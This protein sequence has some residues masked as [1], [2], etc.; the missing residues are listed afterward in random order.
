MAEAF[1][2]GENDEKKIRKW[3][4]E[5]TL[6]QFKCVGHGAKGTHRSVFLCLVSCCVSVEATDTTVSVC[7]CVY[8]SSNWS[9][10]RDG[11]LGSRFAL[12]EL[13]TDRLF[14]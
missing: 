10:K 13:K 7:S 3:Q 2:H 8:S 1:N 4:E 12:L 11:F 5:V 14:F 6:M 9:R